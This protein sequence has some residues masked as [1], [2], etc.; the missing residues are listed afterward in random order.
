MARQMT[1]LRRDSVLA[2]R[3]RCLWLAWLVQVS[4]ASVSRHRREA[5]QFLVK[6]SACCLRM[7]RFLGRLGAVRMLRT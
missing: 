7:C 2:L 5:L 3:R 4:V 6:P 1:P